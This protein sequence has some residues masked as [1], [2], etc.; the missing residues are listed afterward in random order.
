V[1]ERYICTSDVANI[2]HIRA[3]LD[4]ASQT[5][6]DALGFSDIDMPGVEFAIL[7]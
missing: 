2:T 6:L 4:M 5:L 7:H 1:G 3:H